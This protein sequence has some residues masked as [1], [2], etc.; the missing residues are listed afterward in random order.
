[1][2]DEAQLRRVLKKYA[3]YY[4]QVRTHLSLDKNAPDFRRPQ[5]LGP[6][7]AI[8]IFGGIHH[9]PKVGQRQDCVRIT[10]FGIFFPFRELTE[11]FFHGFFRA[12]VVLYPK[13]IANRDELLLEVQNVA[14]KADSLTKFISWEI[15]S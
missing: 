15:Q 6:I 11:S 2:F 5:K 8:P 12:R 14:Y 1:M 4:N 7:A 10:E 13:H 9:Q 3:S